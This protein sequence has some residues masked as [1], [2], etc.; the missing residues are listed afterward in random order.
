MSNQSVLEKYSIV[1]FSPSDWW[2]GK[3]DWAHLTRE[4]SK[5][6]RVLF[7]NTISPSIPSIK[8]ANFLRRL[9]RKLPSVIRIF[10]K[11]LP[12]IYVFT[13][14]VLP[15]S[16][17]QLL[18]Q[19]NALFLPLQLRVLMFLLGFNKSIFWVSNL[20][21]APLLKRLK[22][23]LLVYSCT[24]KFDATRYIKAKEKMSLF[25]EMLVKQADII[26]CVSK[27][28]YRYYKQ[29][30]GNKVHYL[31]HAVDF[32]HFN[33][34]Y[35]V[36]SPPPAEIENI[37]RPVIGYYGS[38][39]DSNDLETLSFCIR[40]RPEWSFVLIGKITGGDFREIQEL[41]NVYMPGYKRYEELPL[42]GI[43]FD[44]CLLFW[45]ITEWIKFCSPYK[46]KEYL[47]M[48]KPVV[49][50]PIPEIEEEFSDV[51]S[52]AKT[53]EEF[54]NAI[55]DALNKD[56]QE[57][58]QARISKVREFTWENYV[59]TFS[60]VLEFTLEKRNEKPVNSEVSPKDLAPIG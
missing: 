3:T 33:N 41:P 1:Y 46:T 22:Y 35:M 6:T 48:G 59:T 55:E 53:K 20:A 47:A 56:T 29:R 57:K 51:I 32:T 17:Y 40:N 23:E 30:A 8:S 4:F 37:P 44:V 5:R 9:K 52:V 27:A 15:F 21:V 50:V 24:D 60:S 43:F 28:L 45:K 16:K 7:V 39:T 25:D 19:I 58:Q 38:L 49:S 42:Y 13:P 10:R 34:V 14:F 18:Q 54:L 2:F 26:L 31:P 12:N 36:K 11:P